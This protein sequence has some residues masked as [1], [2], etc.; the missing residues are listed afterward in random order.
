MLYHCFCFYITFSLSLLKYSIQLIRAQ[1][2][3]KIMNN[4]NY[5]GL[6]NILDIL[7]VYPHN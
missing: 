1:L 3:F 7:H 2:D 5:V 4:P 6:L